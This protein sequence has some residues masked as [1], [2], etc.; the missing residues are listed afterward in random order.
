MVFVEQ[1]IHSGFSENGYLHVIAGGMK[2]GKTKAFIDI[3]DLIGHTDLTFKL[4]KPKCDDREELQRN[5]EI[6]SDHIISRTGTNIESIVIND[7]GQ[8][9]D[10]VEDLKKDDFSKN[11]YGFEEIF[12]LRNPDKLFKIIRYLKEDRGKTVVVSGLDRD[13]KGEPFEIMQYLMPH[14]TSVDKKFAICDYSNGDGTRCREKGEYS[15][16]I[17]NGKPANYKGDV[18][19]VGA[20]EAYEAR[21]AMHHF[22]PGKPKIEL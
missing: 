18:I 10:L 9:D 3:F 6:P 1:I 2:G 17:V 5:G 7:K 14:A 13:F 19:L 20:S 4:Y 16:R 15:Q 11:V 21:C 22:V 8:L 12:L